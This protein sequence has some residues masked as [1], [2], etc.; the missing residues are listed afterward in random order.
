MLEAAE[1]KTGSFLCL[2]KKPHKGK[3]NDVRIVTIICL[4]CHSE[5]LGWVP[6]I[7]LEA[8]NVMNKVCITGIPDLN[9]FMRNWGEQFDYRP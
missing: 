3:T 4:P 2:T 9:D 5:H 7:S 6:V 8:H 1:M